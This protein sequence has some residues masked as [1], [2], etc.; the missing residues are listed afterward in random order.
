MGSVLAVKYI[1]SW[2]PGAGF[3]RYA[4]ETR[5]VV[6]ECLN[7]PF[8]EVKKHMVSGRRAYIVRV[9][10]RAEI[11]CYERRK[12]RQAGLSVRCSFKVRNATR[13]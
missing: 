6:D 9:T 11:N 12:A 8:D 7:R 4:A 10:A 1:P 5:V 2:F 13:S 3:K